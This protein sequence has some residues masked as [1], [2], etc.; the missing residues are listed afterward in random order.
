MAMSNSIFYQLDRA[1]SSRVD[2][3][4]SATRDSILG[5]EIQFTRDT[6]SSVEAAWMEV[7]E[8]WLPVFDEHGWLEGLGLLHV[9]PDLPYGHA[10]ARYHGD[11]IKFDATPDMEDSIDEGDVVG[12]SKEHIFVHE[13][14][15][16]GH[17]TIHGYNKLHHNYPRNLFKDTVSFYSAKNVLEAVAEAGTG[18]IFGENYPSSVHK[19]YADNEGPSEVYTIRYG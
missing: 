18:I 15:H 4:E 8:E 3:W 11:C 16:H 7:F 13:M 17:Q 5:V 14:V 19:V 2:T 1:I 10:T 12:L 6:D 9:G